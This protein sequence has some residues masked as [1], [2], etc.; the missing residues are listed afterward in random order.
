[1]KSDR[2]PLLNV[3][4]LALATIL[5]LAATAYASGRLSGAARQELGH[6]GTVSYPATCAVPLDKSA[7]ETNQL[8]ALLVGSD[9]IRRLSRDQ[10]TARQNRIIQP[11]L[12]GQKVWSRVPLSAD[13]DRTLSGAAMYMLRGDGRV[14]ELVCER[15][16]TLYSL[17]YELNQLLK[18]CGMRF[19][20]A[21]VH[22]WAPL[23][24]FVGL[25]CANSRVLESG[26]DM[27][28]D[29]E[30]TIDSVVRGLI[31]LVPSVALSKLVADT[32][33]P[34]YFKEAAFS[35]M[36][37]YVN[38]VRVRVEFEGATRGMIGSDTATIYTEGGSR[39]GDKLYPV[40]FVF[41]PWNSHIHLDPPKLG[42]LNEGDGDFL[43]AEGRDRRIWDRKDEAEV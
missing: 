12:S 3:R 15:G 5:A 39:S 43:T 16:N 8:N 10:D 28:P 36:P 34:T 41:P 25:A 19:T 26:S 32:A 42:A 2:S 7:K 31:P 9:Y 37:G 30:P 22:A 18:D 27:W 14:H 4:D 6:D 38:K 13:L 23:V 1:M 20:N 35:A 24:I 17:P 21:D 33:G 40:M 11:F 29:F